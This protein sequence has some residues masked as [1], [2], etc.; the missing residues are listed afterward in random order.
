MTSN[1]VFTKPRV[2]IR[3][4]LALS[5]NTSN[6]RKPIPTKKISEI[7][8]KYVFGYDNTSLEEEIGKLLTDKNLTIATAESCSGGRLA[9][10]II[11]VPGSSNYFN[12]SI[13]AYS[14]EAKNKLLGV[15]MET[16]NSVGAVSEECTIEMAQGVR[17]RLGTKYWSFQYRN[18]RSRR[19][20]TGKTS[21]HCLDCLRR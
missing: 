5:H 14:Y 4:S 12:A 15:S 11:S 17:E 21:W 18:C 2:S 6:H 20:N 7:A 8:G 19:R 13:I 9:N 3:L 1:M 10:S 16:L